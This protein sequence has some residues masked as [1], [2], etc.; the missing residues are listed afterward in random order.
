MFTGISAG[1]R[2]KTTLAALA[3]A[4]LVGATIGSSKAGT[5]AAVQDPER[6]ATTPTGWHFWVGQSKAKIDQLA[7]SSSERVVD[8]NV[9]SV[10]PLRFSAVLVRNSGP[11]ARTG[12]WSYGSEADVT[13]TMNAKKARLIDLEPYTYLGQRRFAYVWVKTAATRARTG[14][15]TTT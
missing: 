3:A 11:Y 2:R 8:V 1:L 7:N 13:N 12:S 6:N 9:D 14:T 4:V 10:S 15:G 5:A